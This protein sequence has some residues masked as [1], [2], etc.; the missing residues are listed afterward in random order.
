MFPNRVPTDRDTPSSEPLAKRGDS[1]HSF[2][3]VCLPESPKKGALLHTYRKKHKVTIHRASRRRKAYVQWGAAWFP[4]GIV[5]DTAVSTPVPR[6]FRHDTF[7]LWF[8][9]GSFWLSVLAFQLC[10][11]VCINKCFAGEK[12]CFT[13]SLEPGMKKA[14]RAW[15]GAHDTPSD[16]HGVA[17]RTTEIFSY[18]TSHKI[19][20]SVVTTLVRTC[21]IIA[22]GHFV[23]YV[24]STRTH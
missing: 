4:K 10:D 1:V 2:I 23:C 24:L 3:H 16:A 19:G 22:G 18:C 8:K 17:S 5:N 9:C 6:S 15:L 7:F 13:T 11:T 21:D 20:K 12:L 14:H